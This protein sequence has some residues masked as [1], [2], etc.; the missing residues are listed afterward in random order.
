MICEPSQTGTSPNYY[1]ILLRTLALQGMFV[2]LCPS[3]RE[4]APRVRYND[5]GLFALPKPPSSEQDA[6]IE[7]VSSRCSALDQ[8]ITRSRKELDLISEYRTTLIAEVVTGK[9][10]VREAAKRLPDEAVESLPPD[11]SM[12]EMIEDEVDQE[13]DA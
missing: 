8:T 5:F 11:D 10:D 9:L 7:F 13:D 3:V 4:R 1:A 6:I 2:A 12:D